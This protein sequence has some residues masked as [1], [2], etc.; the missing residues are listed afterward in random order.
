M[1]PFDYVK[2]INSGCHIEEPVTDEYN[3]WLVTFSFSLFPDTIF[4][5]NEVN[6][7]YDLTMQMHYDYLRNSIRPR[8][9]W[10]KWP[11]KD[12]INADNIRL[13]KDVYKYNTRNA[14]EA[15]TLLTEAQIKLIEEQQ[16][17]GG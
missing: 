10:K 14:I 8:R 11:K 9:R 5:A 16:S 3:P 17:T 1:N 4:Q 13:I 12:K 15:L 6:C 2:S 7:L